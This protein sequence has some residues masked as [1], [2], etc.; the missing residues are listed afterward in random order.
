MAR[1]V[2]PPTYLFI[3]IV[4][5]LLLRYGIPG[6]IFLSFPWILLG[7]LPLTFGLVISVM[8]SRAFDAQGTT[9]KPFEESSVLVTDGVFRISR[10]PIYLG[11]TLLLLGVALIL[12]SLYSLV[13]VAVF[14]VLMQIMFIQEEEKMLA[15]QFGEKWEEYRKKVRQWI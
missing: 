8:A 13:V 15:E 11:F 14:A 2:Y 12:G 9:I 3:C 5:M 4:A 6:G 1:R 10:H 7:L